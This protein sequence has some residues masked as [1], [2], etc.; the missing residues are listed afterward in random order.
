[1]LKAKRAVLPKDVRVL[2]VG[3]IAP[4]NMAPWRA[5]GATGFGLGSA[6]YKKGFSAEEVGA[7][8]RAFVAAL[9]G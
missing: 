8:A 7:R 2:A 3:G 4:D 9:A 1:M 6:L 5:A